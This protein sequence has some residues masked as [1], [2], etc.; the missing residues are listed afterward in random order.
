MT[1]NTMI[2]IAAG[3][4]LALLLA[5]WGFQHLG[6]LAPC[7]LCVWQRW[8]HGGAVLAGIGALA[9]T[10]PLMPLLGALMAALTGAIGIYHTGVEQAWWEGPAACSSGPI[11][12][13][14]P[15][16]LMDQ[17]LNAPLVQCDQVAWEFIGLSMASW[18]AVIAFSLMALWLIAAKK[19]G[20]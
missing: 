8:P 4:S 20:R 9:I 11:D 13:L 17:I 15:E 7:K 16:Q 6:G 5:A 2:A 14:T 1:R 12:T 19:S 10:G 18:N 3:G